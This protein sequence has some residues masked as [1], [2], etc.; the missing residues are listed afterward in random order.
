MH[1]DAYLITSIFHLPHISL[2]QLPPCSCYAPFC[3]SLGI[4]DLVFPLLA[5]QIAFPARKGRFF[6][7]SHFA[8]LLQKGTFTASATETGYRAREVA[9]VSLLLL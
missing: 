9:V 4:H 1:R 3:Y 5:F 6:P 7:F 2:L 8:A